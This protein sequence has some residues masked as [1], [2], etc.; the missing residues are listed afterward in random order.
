MDGETNLKIRQALP[1]T[2]EF[3][4]VEK[5]RQISAEIECELPNRKVTEFTGTMK[6]AGDRV[7]LCKQFTDKN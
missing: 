4:N 7:P 1:N 6:I 3:S 5:I 2:A